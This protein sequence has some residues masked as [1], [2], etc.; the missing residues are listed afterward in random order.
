MAGVNS[1]GFGGGNAHA[2]LRWN[3]HN[4]AS[5]DQALK[6]GLPRLV[7]VS[8]RTEEAVETILH[9]VKNL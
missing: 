4:K 1:F 7:V 5:E 9:E 8:G 6:D 3:P 2:V